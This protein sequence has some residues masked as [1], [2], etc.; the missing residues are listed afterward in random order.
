MDENSTLF[1]CDFPS[2]IEEDSIKE[3]FK[4]YKIIN[5]SIVR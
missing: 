2:E 3:F 1:I 4:D 5:I